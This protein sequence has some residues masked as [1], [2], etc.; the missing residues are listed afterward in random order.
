MG[1]TLGKTNMGGRRLRGSKKPREVARN[2]RE[3]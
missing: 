2:W 3:P 1:K